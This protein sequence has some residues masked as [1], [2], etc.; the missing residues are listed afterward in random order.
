M[1]NKEILEDF[2]KHFPALTKE[3]IKK[4]EY[5]GMW[6]LEIH[7]VNGS[8]GL[9]DAILHTFKYVPKNGYGE[10]SKNRWNLELGAKINRTLL[11]RGYQLYE[12]AERTGIS[13]RTLSNIINGHHTTSTYTL[14]QIAKALGVTIGYL[15]DFERYYD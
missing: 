4:V 12:L 6:I 8:I 7:Y 14:V 9:Y 11:M 10:I 3:E 2:R 1:T 5:L 15:T 13:E